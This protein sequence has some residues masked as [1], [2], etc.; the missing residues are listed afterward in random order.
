MLFSFSAVTTPVPLRDICQPRAV[1]SLLPLP[2]VDLS[3]HVFLRIPRREQ[4]D[5]ET[6]AIQEGDEEFKADQGGS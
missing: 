2:P 5:E 6:E 3:T 4:D 1:L